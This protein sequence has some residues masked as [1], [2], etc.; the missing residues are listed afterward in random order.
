ML[1]RVSPDLWETINNNLHWGR[2]TRVFWYVGTT[3]SDD[4]ERKEQKAGGV[5]VVS[6]MIFGEST[7]F[8]ISSMHAVIYQNLV[9]PSVV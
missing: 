6:G 2:E 7:V 4:C 5:S 1:T 9:L 8:V 3:P